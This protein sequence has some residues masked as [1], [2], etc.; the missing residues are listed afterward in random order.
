MGPMVFIVGILSIISG[1]YIMK[2]KRWS[3]ALIGSIC[4]LFITWVL[5]EGA[6]TTP[7]ALKGLA[8]I[9]A[10]FTVVLTIMSRKHLSK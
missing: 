2:I 4:V 8:W 10:I 7:V 5:F 6:T 3:L 9:P 1:R